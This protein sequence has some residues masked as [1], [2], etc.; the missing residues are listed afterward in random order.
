MLFYEKLN[1]P[2]RVS[3]S[4]K[5]KLVVDEINVKV[6]YRYG[7]QTCVFYTVDGREVLFQRKNKL[8]RMVTE[9]EIE[10]SCLLTA[11][12]VSI[13]KL[14]DLCLEKSAHHIVKIAPAPVSYFNKRDAAAHARRISAGVDE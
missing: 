10:C 7:I 1:Q 3:M 11:R 5:V 8:V 13:K 14:L 2:W 12:L 4:D 9:I 6:E